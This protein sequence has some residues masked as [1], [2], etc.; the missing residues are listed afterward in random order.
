MPV[1][2]SVALRS[3]LMIPLVAGVGAAAEPHNGR[4]ALARPAEGIRV[5][6]DFSD[7]PASARRY[8]IARSCAAVTGLRFRVMNL[9][10][11][12]YTENWDS[13]FPRSV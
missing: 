3:L 1:A 12:L 8:P 9:R 6:G 5:D 2:S 10:N 4:T 11:V 7:W 13:E